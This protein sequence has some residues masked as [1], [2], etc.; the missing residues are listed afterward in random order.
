MIYEYNQSSREEYLIELYKGK[1][2]IKYDYDFD[3]ESGSHVARKIVT[4]DGLLR[5]NAANFKIGQ[6]IKGYTELYGECLYGCPGN[7]KSQIRLK[8][9]FKATVLNSPKVVMS[10]NSDYTEYE[11]K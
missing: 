3:G 8:G 7:D 9:Y 5:L 4:V 10:V 6:E 11:V 2:K 1:F